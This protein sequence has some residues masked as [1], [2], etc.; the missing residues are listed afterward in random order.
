M[1]LFDWE[2]NDVLVAL[3]YIVVFAGWAIAT[4]CKLFKAGTY[5][6]AD[7]PSGLAA[8]LAAIP[9]AKAVSVGLQRFGKGSP[10]NTPSVGGKG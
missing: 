6:V 7:F 8:V 9:L 5:E 4:C 1:F 2:K 3:I 10:Q